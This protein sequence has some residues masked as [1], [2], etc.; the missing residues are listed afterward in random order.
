[1]PW[2]GKCK[3]VYYPDF[4]H[5]C[6][7]LE[8][9]TADAVRRIVREE[10]AGIEWLTREQMLERFPAPKRTTQRRNGDPT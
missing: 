8:P 6:K 3:M 5:R 10:I 2:C 9:M 7:P 1:M 4:G